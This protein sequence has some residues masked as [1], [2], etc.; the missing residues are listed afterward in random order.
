MKNSGYI[1]EILKMVV[2]GGYRKWW[3]KE[4]IGRWKPKE[5]RKMG[6]KREKWWSKVSFASRWAIDA[7]KWRLI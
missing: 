7:V 2:K 4:T 1:K 3:P 6:A 5:T